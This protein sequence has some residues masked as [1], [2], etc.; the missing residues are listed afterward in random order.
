MVDTHDVDIDYSQMKIEDAKNLA[1]YIV[2]YTVLMGM[3]CALCVYLSISG[4]CIA[5]ISKAKTG[6]KQTEKLILIT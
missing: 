6:Q 1:H 3:S 5:A 4:C 2:S